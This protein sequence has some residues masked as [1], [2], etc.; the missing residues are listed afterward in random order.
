MNETLENL[1]YS[2]GLT[3]Q[4]GWDALDTYQRDCVVKLV[5]L[6]VRECVDKIETYRIPVGNSRSGE[7]A[8]EWTYSALKEIRDDICELFEVKYA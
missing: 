4:G 3:A 7:L 5:E 8:C 1:L 6:T 2:S